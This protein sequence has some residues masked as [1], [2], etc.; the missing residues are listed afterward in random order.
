MQDPGL[1][2][3]VDRVTRLEHDL[4]T[5]RRLGAVAAVVGA[6]FAAVIVILVLHSTRAAIQAERFVFRDAS[7]RTRATL[8]VSGEPLV[9][10]LVE[11]GG[12]VRWRAP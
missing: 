8:I 2:Q 12:R 10:E 3:L 6:G 9:L 5:L 11:P 4:A 1:G 7:G